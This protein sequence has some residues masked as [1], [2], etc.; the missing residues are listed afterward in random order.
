MTRLDNQ[1]YS[2]TD[3]PSYVKLGSYTSIGKGVIFH[4]LNWE[5]RCSV[6]HK[7]VYTY[8]W[9]QPRETGEIVIGSDVWIA[10]DV[11]ILP[12]I[13]IGDGAIIG[14]GSVVTHDVEPYA[15]VVG[16]PG[17]V[18]RFRFVST[19]VKKLMKMKWWEWDQK[20]ITERLPEMQHVNEFLLKYYEK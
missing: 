18:A 13:H 16:N 10:D 4:P 2:V 20:I 9:D 3:L 19:I 1:S 17:K 5:H 6:N 15:V 8:N 14:A 12:N 11:R 7:C